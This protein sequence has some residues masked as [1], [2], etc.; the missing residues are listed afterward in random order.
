[1]YSN[2]LVVAV[3]HDGKVLREVGDCVSLPFN[4]EYSLLI[5]NLNSRKVSVNISIDG[6]DVLDGKSLL[7]QSDSKA[8]LEGFLKG[9]IAKN[10]FKFIEKT[11][12]ISKYRGDK[13]DDGLIRVEFSFEKE[14]PKVTYCYNQFYD[15]CPPLRRR[16]FWESVN[17]TKYCSDS[18]TNVVNCSSSN[19]LYN[20]DSFDNSGITV[21]GSEINQG[22]VYG[23]IGELENPQVM[24]IHLCG[25]KSN[26]TAVLK[27]ISIK[28][29]LRCKTCGTISK[30]SAKFCSNCGTFLE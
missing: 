2:K 9:K 10:K 19:V 30:S 11:K 13:I 6:D 8:E 7:I 14:Q 29:R 3:K 25:K 16:C 26:G 15:Y 23:N 21:K 18:D 17:S 28:T 4:S 20:S 5:K 22:F 27:P 24:V 12:Q 1:M